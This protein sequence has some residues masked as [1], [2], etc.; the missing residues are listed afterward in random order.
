MNFYV[1]AGETLP[2]RKA[3]EMWDRLEA[4][5]KQSYTDVGYKFADRFNSGDWAPN[6]FVDIEPDPTKF[7]SG[8]Y[9][10]DWETGRAP[11][12]ALDDQGLYLEDIVNYVHDSLNG[13]QPI[14]LHWISWEWY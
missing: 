10:H 8:F 11:F 6:D 14:T 13:G 3:E 12:W 9:K 1:K 2:V 5:G 4:F 7:I